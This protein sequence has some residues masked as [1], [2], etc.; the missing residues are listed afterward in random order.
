MG[1]PKLASQGNGEI[2]VRN[3]KSLEELE[4]PKAHEV[5]LELL[6]EY[7]RT[8]PKIERVLLF[9]SC[10][11]GKASQ[12]SDLDLFLIGSDLSDED[13]WDIAWNCPSFTEPGRITCDL[14]SGTYESYERMSKIP[15]MVQYA[16][17]L[18]GAD[19]SGLLHTC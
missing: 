19:L 15:G 17:E 6:L 18:R 7:F 10:A 5:Y 16:I 9:G 8:Y 1:S 14:L 4:M 11:S 13:E 12:K 2:S 3:I